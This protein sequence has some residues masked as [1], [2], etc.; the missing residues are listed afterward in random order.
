MDG[1]DVLFRI[2]LGIL[3]SNEA[4]L[5][6]CE[7]VPAVYVSLENLPTRMW[8]ADKL[9]QVGILSSLDSHSSTYFLFYFCFIINSSWKQTFEVR[10][11]IHRLLAN[12]KHMSRRSVNSFLRS[13]QNFPGYYYLLMYR[14]ISFVDHIA[15]LLYSHKNFY[16]IPMIIARHLLCL[17]KYKAWACLP[18]ANGIVRM[19]NSVVADSDINRS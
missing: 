14:R 8:E 15:Y 1:L 18:N 3:R 16:L 9:L 6:R 7:S 19:E 5:L 17:M 12:V 4:E 11:F 10:S 2:A 13:I